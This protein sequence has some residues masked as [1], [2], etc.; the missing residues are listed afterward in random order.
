MTATMTPAGT[1]LREQLGLVVQLRALLGQFNDGIAIVRET[2]DVQVNAAALL[3]EGSQAQLTRNAHAAASRAL[4]TME[5]A[6]TL[7]D[8]YRAMMIAEANS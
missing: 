7:L 8:E 2:L 1:R 4:A 6:R 3:V 5:D